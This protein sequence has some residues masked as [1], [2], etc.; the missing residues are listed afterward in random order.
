M[1]KQTANN[2]TPNRAFGEVYTAKTVKGEKQVSN[3][4]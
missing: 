3:C 4:F 1:K 2:D